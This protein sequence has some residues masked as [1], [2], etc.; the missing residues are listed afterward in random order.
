[1]P[2]CR[3]HYVNGQVVTAAARNVLESRKV[4]SES[5]VEAAAA[6]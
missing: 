4:Q 6:I 5:C 1:M 2:V 3:Q